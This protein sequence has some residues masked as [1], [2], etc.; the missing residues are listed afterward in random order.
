MLFSKNQA[1]LFSFLVVGKIYILLGFDSKVIALNYLLKA[2][3]KTA[4]IWR[5]K[6]EYIYFSC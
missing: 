3:S 6:L 1:K 2:F 5:K 4:L